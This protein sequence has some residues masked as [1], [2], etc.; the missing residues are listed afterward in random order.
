MNTMKIMKEIAVM[1]NNDLNELVV[2]VK[3]RRAALSRNAVATFGVGD[4]V[5]FVGRDGVTVLGTVEKTAIKNVTVKT[6][7]GRWKVSGTLLSMA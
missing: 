4:R 6:D 2:A 1:S 5:S 3:A 7:I